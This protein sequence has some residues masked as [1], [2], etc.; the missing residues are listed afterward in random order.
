MHVRNPKPRLFCFE[1]QWVVDYLVHC[2][3]RGVEFAR[4]RHYSQS[5]S[6]PLFSRPFSLW[7]R[8]ASAYL[9]SLAQSP[10]LLTSAGHWMGWAFTAKQWTDGALHSLLAAWGLATRRD[11]E[12]ALH[13]LQQ[14][15]GRLDD[16]EFRLA[17]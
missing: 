11:Q 14:I 4:R 6:S 9:E 10:L 17:G 15:E 16:L 12:K 1:L 13:L 3:N 2:N 5:M 7:Q 8:A